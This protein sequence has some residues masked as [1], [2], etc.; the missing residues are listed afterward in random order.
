MSHNPFLCFAINWASRLFG[1]F[2]SR[3]SELEIEGKKKLRYFGLDQDGSITVQN[4][5]RKGIL[6]FMNILILH[7]KRVKENQKLLSLLR[8]V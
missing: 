1:L 8:S 3:V 7:A 6:E 5:F 4:W 2:D